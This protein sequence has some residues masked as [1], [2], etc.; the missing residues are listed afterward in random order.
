M[1]SLNTYDW[2]L[3]S[4]TT[5]LTVLTPVLKRTPRVTMEIRRFTTPSNFSLRV[6]THIK[7]G[8]AVAGSQILDYF[9]TQLSTKTT[10]SLTLVYYSMVVKKLSTYSLLTRNDS[11][12]PLASL[13]NLFDNLWWLEREASE[14]YGIFFE[15]KE[16]HRNLLL[17]YLNVF[18][19]GL[20]TFPSSGI[21]EVFFHSILR[22][23]LT[24]YPRSQQI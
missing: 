21:F 2:F 5:K 6:S 17:E 8:A 20:R 18:R 10:Y 4:V 19:P 12:L 13:D 22:T 3:S 7:F 1:T 11:F 9:S 16:D 23:L 24:R 15:F 14:S